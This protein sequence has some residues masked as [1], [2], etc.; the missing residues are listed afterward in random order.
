MAGETRNY[1]NSLANYEEK[2]AMTVLQEAK[3]EARQACSRAAEILSGRGEYARAWREYVVGYVTMH[4]SSSR[5]L[6]G[7]I[8]L[9]GK[10]LDG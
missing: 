8:G 3:S 1:I 7:E 6:F 10:F 5:Y 4:L 2:S 9:D